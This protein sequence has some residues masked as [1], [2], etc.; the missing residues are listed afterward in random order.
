[1]HNFIVFTSIRLNLQ[2]FFSLEALLTAL[3]TTLIAIV[4]DF[5][6]KS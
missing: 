4:H 5:E 3:Y 6:V 1:M 2:T